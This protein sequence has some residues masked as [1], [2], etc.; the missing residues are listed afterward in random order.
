MDWGVL[1][2]VDVSEDEIVPEAIYQ[3]QAIHC[4]SDFDDENSY[5]CPLEIETSIWGDVV[6]H[7]AVC[8]CTPPNGS[9]DITDVTAVL[10][11]FKNLLCA[12]RK[13]RADV[14]PDIPNRQVDF[15]D[16]YNVLDAFKGFDYPFDGPDEC[17]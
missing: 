8:P 6:G 4:D 10:D 11:K 1:G 9:V 17:P 13:A 2:L 3:V 12:P 14:A 5:T 7:C 16:I 15:T